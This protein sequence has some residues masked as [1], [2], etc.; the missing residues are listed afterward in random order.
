MVHLDLSGSEF[1]LLA[2]ESRPEADAHWDI[3]AVFSIFSCRCAALGS[4]F[5]K[6]RRVG[7]VDTI[8]GRSAS[9]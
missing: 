9:R 7:A 4:V 1:S 5:L 3:P 2:S 8:R 6:Y